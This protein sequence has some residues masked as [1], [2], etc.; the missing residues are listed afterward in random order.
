MMHVPKPGNPPARPVQIP[1]LTPRLLAVLLNPACRPQRARWM[2]LLLLCATIYA[3]GL[4]EFIA[5]CLDLAKAMH[6]IAR[7][8]RPLP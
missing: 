4:P 8:L 6:S 3:G 5:L 2:V 7:L 1:P